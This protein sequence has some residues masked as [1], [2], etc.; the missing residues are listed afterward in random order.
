M[1]FVWDE[2]KNQLNIKDHKVSLNET[3]D[4]GGK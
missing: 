4:Y 3:K 1:K 2:N